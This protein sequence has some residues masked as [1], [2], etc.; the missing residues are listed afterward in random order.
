MEGN[1][2]VTTEQLTST[3]EEFSSQGSVISNL[4]NEMVQKV[5]ALSSA[6][7]GEAATA[8]INKFN[9]LEDDIQKIIRMVSEHVQDLNNMAAAYKQAENTN[10]EEINGLSSDVIV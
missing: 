1:I 10:L 9:S 4:T 5:T 8:Y 7:E 3:A 2:L 6:W